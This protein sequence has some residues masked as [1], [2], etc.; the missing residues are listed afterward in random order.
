MKNFV[1]NES[2]VTVV[3]EPYMVDALEALKLTI[4]LSYP[5]LH[6]PQL[7]FHVGVNAPPAPLN[8][9]PTEP[10]IFGSPALSLIFQ[11]V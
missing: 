3:E 9:S 4:Y 11:D 2:G 1:F 5:L 6:P 7:S 8:N 10:V